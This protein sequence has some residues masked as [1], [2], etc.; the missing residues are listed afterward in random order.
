[1]PTAEAYPQSACRLTVPSAE[2]A[3]RVCNKSLF[4]SLTQSLHS[5]KPFKGGGQKSLGERGERER[6]ITR[7]SKRVFPSRK[8]HPPSS[9]GER[10]ERERGITRFSKRVSPSR[11]TLLFVYSACAADV[12]E[13]GV[14]LN[15]IRAAETSV[16]SAQ[17][18]R[19]RTNVHP[20]QR[21]AYVDRRIRLY[22]LRQYGLP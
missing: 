9:L 7:F 17:R 10:G 20:Y 1:M 3:L 18:H 22:R 5:P 12:G 13:T 8:L 14:G 16:C 11:N 4:P 2:E 6:G 21:V 15:E 19:Y